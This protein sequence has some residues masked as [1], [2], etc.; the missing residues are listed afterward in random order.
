LKEE[1]MKLTCPK[2]DQHIETPDEAK[3]GDVLCPT[4]AHEFKPWETAA[5]PPAPETGGNKIQE[6]MVASLRGKA[7]FLTICAVVC[8]VGAGVALAYG[9][10]LAGD[11]PRPFSPAM[12]IGA[13][14]A[15]LWFSLL[16]LAQLFHI[17]ALLEF[18]RGK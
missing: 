3:E 7:E 4:C 9:W 6:A 16:I 1:I 2:C 5:A 15:A 8:F 11:S 17:R 10:A 12:L 18:Q 13:A 14:C